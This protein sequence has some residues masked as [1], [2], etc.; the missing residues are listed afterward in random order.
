MHL[1]GKLLVGAIVAASA[2]FLTWPQAFGSQ[3]AFGVAQL[4]AFRPVLG[5]GFAGCASTAALLA[6]ARRD[7]G[8]GCPAV[9]V[10]LVLFAAVAVGQVAVLTARWSLCS[11]RR[12]DD[13]AATPPCRSPLAGNGLRYQHRPPGDLAVVQ[14][15]KGLRCV[16][17]RVPNDLDRD[18]AGPCERNDL[19]HVCTRAAVCPLD[20]HAPR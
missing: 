7:R 13:T 16:V 9:I 18:F 8:R 10:L 14:V 19:A 11:P 1:A 5:I 15:L 2:L 12:G 4:L 20:V 3:R 6:I 17:E